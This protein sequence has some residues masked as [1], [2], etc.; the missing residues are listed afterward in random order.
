MPDGP[1]TGA[2]APVTAPVWMASP[3][4]VHSARL[5]SGP[6]PGPLLAA[7]AAWTAL[8]ADYHSAADELGMLLAA[9]QAEA[10]Q[11]PSAERYVTAKTRYLGWLTQVCAD[12]ATVAARHE[13]AASAYTAA[14]ATMPTLAELAANHAA[15]AVLAGTNFFGINTI[16]IALNEADYA[17]MWIQ[18]A[19]AMSTYQAVSAAAAASVPPAVP[20]PRLL[21]IE[22]NPG[23][24]DPKVGSPLDMFISQILKNFGVN[25]DP[26][27]GTLNGHVYDFYANAN[28][29]IWY[30][31]R[32]LELLENFQ[33]ALAQNP[34][35]ALQ[36][37]IILAIFDWPTHIAQLTT[38]L[39]QS[40]LLLAVA[41]AAVAPA[42][43]LS[44]L[45]GLAGPAGLPEAGTPLP[46]PA[47]PATATPP[48]VAAAGSA[49]AAS[50]A[51]AAPPPATAGPAVTSPAAP[52]PTPPA[53]IEA[54]VYPY[55]V[56]GGPGAG[57]GSGVSTGASAAAG[58]GNKAPAPDT[59]AARD[60]APTRGQ[61]RA[62]RRRRAVRRDG[63]DEFMDMSVG[64]PPDDGV[65]QTPEQPVRPVRP[66]RPAGVTTLAGD[67]FG[68]GPPVPL[69][70]LPPDT[71]P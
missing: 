13:T 19:T 5:S 33:Y 22:D 43:S 25:W 69:L 23:A 4:E 14:L 35:G 64:T 63:A 56:G 44:G 54:F 31:A 20:A 27:A 11:G 28:Q 9:V 71:R 29:P 52:P 65:G 66:V 58:A 46:A 10:W 42:G 70:P 47:A 16:P 18:A 50:A 1:A 40:S 51:P 61:T 15:H 32:V 6:G 62:R 49:V 7:S 8:S 30:L 38:T 41:G 34:A 2:R 17:R 39:S 37:L 26:T 55:L 57:F 36:Y 60:T 24:H 68:G 21:A 12:S 67:E 59:A 53:G 3:P 48:P 45:A